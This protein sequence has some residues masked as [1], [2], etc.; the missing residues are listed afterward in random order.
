MHKKSQIPNGVV[1]NPGWMQVQPKNNE[2]YTGYEWAEGVTYRSAAYWSGTPYNSHC[3]VEFSEIKLYVSR[4]VNP[5]TY[6]KI[7]ITNVEPTGNGSVFWQHLNQIPYSAFTYVEQTGWTWEVPLTNLNRFEGLNKLVIGFTG[8]ETPGNQEFS[9][10]T[11]F[12]LYIHYYV[13]PY[14]PGNFTATQYG[15]LEWTHPSG[16]RDGYHIHL[17]TD[18]YFSSYQQFTVDKFATFYQLYGLQ[19]NTHYYV[20][21]AGYRQGQSGQYNGDF[22]YTEFWTPAYFYYIY[23]QGEPI[24]QALL[25]PQRNIHLWW[26]WR[27]NSIP[28]KYGSYTD[29]SEVTD[30]GLFDDI[31]SDYTPVKWFRGNPRE[32]YTYATM[33]YHCWLGGYHTDFVNNWTFSNRIVVYPGGGSDPVVVSN[34]DTLA[35]YPWWSPKIAID[36]LENLHIVYTSRDSVYYTFSNDKGHTFTYPVPIA[37]GKFPAIAISNLG[38]EIVYLHHNKVFLI[39]KNEGWTQPTLIYENLSAIN[40]LPPAFGVDRN[41][42]FAYL[43]WEEQTTDYAQ[44]NTGSIDLLNPVP[45]TA[46]TLDRSLNIQDFASPSIS[47]KADGTPLIVWSKLGV[48]YL[49]DGIETKIVETGDGFAINPMVTAVGDCSAS[50]ES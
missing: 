41:T 34:I 49:N 30:Y 6:I 32:G 43:A 22:A 48:V 16:P 2:L 10:T 24:S 39:R 4:V 18:P 3:K 20:R 46:H 1:W 14:A 40:L 9:K 45:I 50:D 5:S 35:L 42:N 47:V 38:L 13:L 23:L 33:P 37:Q 11:D 25:G 15:W 17:S 7:Y 8:Q 26:R 27:T 19:E 31:Y 44:V 12:E 21:I 28:N 36:S 29:S